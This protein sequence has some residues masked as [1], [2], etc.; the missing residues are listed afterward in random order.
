M[1]DTKLPD[2]KEI[3]TAANQPLTQHSGDA[4]DA[5]DAK[6]HATRLADDFLEKGNIDG[7]LVWLKI[8][9][10]IIELTGT[11]RAGATLH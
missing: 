8:Y 11:E 10:A 1:T 4:G 3:Y 9:K 7:H 6:L 2:D 5:G